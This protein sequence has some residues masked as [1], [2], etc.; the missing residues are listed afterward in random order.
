[1]ISGDQVIV[2]PY[3]ITCFVVNA[4]ELLHKKLACSEVILVN[5]IQRRFGVM[6]IYLQGFH[7]HQI[8]YRKL[9]MRSTDTITIFKC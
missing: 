6:V 8:S 3:K 9:N 4:P 1:M 5:H 7:F 2:V